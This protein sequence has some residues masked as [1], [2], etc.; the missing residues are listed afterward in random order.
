MVPRCGF[1][2]LSLPFFAEFVDKYNQEHF[3][4]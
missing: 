2:Q 4:I 1:V 3:L